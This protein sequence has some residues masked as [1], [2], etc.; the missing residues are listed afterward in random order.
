[1]GSS[2]GDGTIEWHAFGNAR[3]EGTDPLGPDHVFRI[4]SNTKAITTVAALQLMEKGLITLDGPLNELMPEMVSIPVLMNN[5]ELKNCDKPITLRQLLTHT[6]GFAYDFTSLKLMEFKAEK[7]EGWKHEDFPRIFEPGEKWFYGTS[8][9]WVGKIVEKISGKDLQT[10][11]E[12]NI[13]KQLKMNS[14]WFNVQEDQQDRIVSW[15]QRSS[16]DPYMEY[17][18]IDKPTTD[19]RGDYGLF[20]SPNDY[21]KFLTCLL[22]GGK[23]DGGEILTKETIDLMQE[24]HLAKDLKIEWEKIPSPIPEEMLGDYVDEKD[25]W[26]L[27]WALEANPEDTVRPHGAGYWSGIANTYY[28]IDIKNKTAVL[29]FSNFFPFNDKEAYNFYRLFEKEVYNTLK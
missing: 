26:G 29:Y 4:W 14:T 6:S 20:S 18:R 24:D 1:M 28:T 23:Y 25:R 9:M 21:C 17:P 16:P 5:G 27:A 13:F 19:L 10:Y 22:N 15:G 7:P 3:W 11:F 12:E 8:T 2:H